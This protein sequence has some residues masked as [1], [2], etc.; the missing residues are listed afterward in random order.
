M[1]GPNVKTI[2]NAASPLAADFI[3]YLQG[4]LTPSGPLQQQATGPTTR[5]GGTFDPLGRRPGGTF[6]PI[7]RTG[8][9]PVTGGGTGGDFGPNF[10]GG[11]GSA[12]QSATS[13]IQSFVDFAQQGIRSGGV[14][15]GTQA[16]IDALM[17]NSAVSTNRQAADQR[18]VFGAAGSRFGTQVAN[19]EALLRGEAERNV[20]QTIAGVLAQRQGQNEANLLQSLA[21]L[22]QQ[23]IQNIQ[24]FLAALGIGIAPAENVV[25]PSIG[26]Q[27]LTGGIDIASSFAGK[28]R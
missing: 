14:D 7:G 18:E 20:G 9:V 19:S 26:S 12:G 25:S 27:L 22:Q 24:P 2:D 21:L 11:I 5:T 15:P 10:G 3:R 28:G 13:G 16:L 23:G 4:Q 17:A 1:G 6:N 8:G